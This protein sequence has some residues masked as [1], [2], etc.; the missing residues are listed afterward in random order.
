MYGKAELSY[1]YGLTCK[2]IECSARVIPI[3]CHVVSSN[4]VCT[5]Q[6]EV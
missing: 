1:W 3:M 6:Q 4:V 2:T 5:Q